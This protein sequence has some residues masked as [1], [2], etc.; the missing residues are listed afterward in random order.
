[1][2]KKYKTI[3]HS[4]Y[5][6]YSIPDTWVTD[7]DENG[8]V[9]VYDE[10]GT[11]TLT[12]S[13]YSIDH[14]PGSLFSYVSTIQR[15]TEE[16]GEMEMNVVSLHHISNDGK[17]TLTSEGKTKDGWL[18]TLWIIAKQRKFIVATYL[19]K[20]KTKE[21]KAMVDIINSMSL[22]FPN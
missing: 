13:F 8:T 11:G 10:K 16:Q 1:M 17:H 15:R 14:D 2:F 9:A 3:Q 22:N 20:K 5:L 7:T 12:M 6:T 21:H 18:I 4:D 19:Y